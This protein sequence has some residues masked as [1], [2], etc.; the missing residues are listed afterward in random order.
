MDLLF[1]F[2]LSQYFSHVSELNT[3]V[4]TTYLFRPGMDIIARII[5]CLSI[6]IEFGILVQERRGE[7][8]SSM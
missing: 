2:S 1:P 3:K 4:E 8:R 7:E 6:F 5:L